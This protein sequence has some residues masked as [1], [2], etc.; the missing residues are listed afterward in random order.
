MSFQ[1]T[2]KID[3]DGNSSIGW[4]GDVNHILLLGTL[5]SIKHGILRTVEVETME[6]L[7]QLEEAAAAQVEDSVDGE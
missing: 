6:K 5:E 7:R 2:L 3:D 1:L 4:D